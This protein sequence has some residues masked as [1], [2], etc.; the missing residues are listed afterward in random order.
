MSRESDVI[1]RKNSQKN[2]MYLFVGMLSVFIVFLIASYFVSSKAL[3][4][5]E[6]DSIVL[7]VA[8]RQRMLIQKNTKE[9][10]RGLL[11]LQARNS[12]I[13]A[14][15][16]ATIQISEDRKAYTIH[17]VAKL[18]DEV[19][20]VHS[21]MNYTAVKGGIPLPATFIKEVSGTIKKKGHYSYELLSKWNINKN[22]GL[23]TDFEKQAFDYL[24]LNSGTSFSRY[25]IYDG[26]YTLRY[27]TPDFAV[28]DECVRCHNAH[29]ESPKNNFKLGDIMGM[30]VVNIP[31]GSD[32]KETELF[33]EGSGDEIF[34]FDSFSKTERFFELTIDALINGGKVPLDMSLTSFQSMPPPTNSEV[35]NKLKM[36]KQKWTAMQV[37]F[38]NLL[39]VEPNSSE[40]AAVFTSAYNSTSTLVDIMDS[41]IHLIQEDSQRK[42]Y[43]IK[44]LQKFIY[45]FMGFLFCFIIVTVYLKVVLPLQSHRE[46]LEKQREGLMS[47]SLELSKSLDRDKQQNWLRIGQADLNDRMRGAEDTTSLSQNIISYLAEYL[48]VQVGTIYLAEDNYTLCL[49]GSYAIKNCD[50]L[51]KEIHFGEGL[52]GQVALNKQMRIVSSIPKCYREINSGLA[53]LLPKNLLIAPCLYEGC[54]KGIIEFGAVHEFTNKHL[55]F[56][57]QVA[58][59]IAIAINTVQ[60]RQCLKDLLEETQAQAEK[61]QA[62]NKELISVNEEL[63]MHSIPGK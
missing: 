14:A 59:S 63:E 36:I 13:K 20:E 29:E 26:I 41:V 10:V 39:T 49:T 34:G 8:G 45:I 7:N 50:A 38:K 58:D 31:I 54:V 48:N 33:F 30:L 62:G 17:V 19:P 3:K 60:S 61:L 40:Y 47:L 35:K 52:I 46:T 23:R 25:M 51:P 6:N 28:S 37:E 12:T 2:L 55:E 1:S 42:L 27:A 15:E 16:V 4:S 53:M 11:L 32:S 5:K 22:K 44:T 9:F 18:K 24:S 21:D 56:M 57:N 43:K